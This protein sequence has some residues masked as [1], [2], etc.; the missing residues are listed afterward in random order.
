LAKCQQRIVDYLKEV[1]NLELN[2][3]PF[4]PTVDSKRAVQWIQQG[5]NPEWTDDKGNTVLCNAVLANNLDLVKHLVAAQSN[6]QHKNLLKQKPLSIA[7]NAAQKNPLIIAFLE[8]EGINRRLQSLIRERKADLTQME[9]Q[10][11]LKQGAD[12]NVLGPNNDSLLHLLV[13]NNGTPEFI[14]V[15]VNSFNADIEM[16]NLNGHRPIEACI[17]HDKLEQLEAFFKLTKVGTEHFF[18]QKLNKSL[19]TF[20]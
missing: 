16:M 1:F 4:Q 15:F 14:S 2:Q 3:I 11:L 13:A 10:D 18:N 6:T 5:A 12:I 9:V 19:L 7:K 8:N 20:A 17:V